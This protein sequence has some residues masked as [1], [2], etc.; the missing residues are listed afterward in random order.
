MTSLLLLFWALLEDP[1]LIPAVGEFEG[2]VV[3]CGVERLVHVLDS[4]P[5][6]AL[7][8]FQKLLLPH[9]V[10]GE[11]AVSPARRNLDDPRWRF[12]I[13]WYKLLTASQATLPDVGCKLL[14]LLH[15]HLW[16]AGFWWACLMLPGD[17]ERHGEARLARG[18]VSGLHAAS[19][20]G[21]H[22]HFDL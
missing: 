11:T 21:R 18:A 10:I 4:I 14:P 22:V 3:P 9:G 2:A 13:W 19:H 8:Q 6:E 20:R 1:H 5:L 15:K 7:Q 16:V 17:V 12:A